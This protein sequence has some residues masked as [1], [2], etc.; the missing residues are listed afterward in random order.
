MIGV[1]GMLL[2]ESTRVLRFLVLYALLYP[3]L[4]YS[5]GLLMLKRQT[6]VM[7]YSQAGNALGV[8]VVLLLLSK[9]APSLGGIMGAA[10]LSFG[11]AVELWIVRR[12]LGRINHTVTVSQ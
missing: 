5:N 7:A 11:V 2:A 8:L 4:D 1:E 10:A 6:G 12:N 3:F 9:V